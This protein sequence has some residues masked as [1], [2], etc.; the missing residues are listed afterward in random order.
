MGFQ[1]KAPREE[2]KCVFLSATVT[3]SIFKSGKGCYSQTFLEECEYKM[4][5]IKIKSFVEDDLESSPDDNDDM[6]MAM[7]KRKKKRRRRKLR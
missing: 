4:K 1:G 6:I 7:N 3:Y 2:F 5:K